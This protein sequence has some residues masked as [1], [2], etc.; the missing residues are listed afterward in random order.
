MVDFLK[1]D[2]PAVFWHDQKTVTEPYLIASIQKDSTFPF[3]LR[4]PQSHINPTDFNSGQGWIL[5]DVSVKSDEAIEAMIKSVTIKYSR[6]H[7]HI[8]LTFQI[9]YL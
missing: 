5:W 7:Y 4:N 2:N 3:R 1:V 6:H 9:H 8:N